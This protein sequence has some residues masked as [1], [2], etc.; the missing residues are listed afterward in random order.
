MRR[1]VGRWGLLVAIL[2]VGMALTCLQN[3]GLGLLHEC[4][5]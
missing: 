3:R 4:S 1:G 5:Q 2:V